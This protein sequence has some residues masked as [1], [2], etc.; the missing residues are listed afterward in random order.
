MDHLDEWA[1]WNEADPELPET[2]VGNATPLTQEE[3][4]PIE[5]GAYFV[6][7]DG[8]PSTTAG[9]TFLI[10]TEGWIGSKEGVNFN[11]MNGVS[12][13][14][15]HLKL[16]EEPFTPV[17]GLSGVTAGVPLPAGSTAADLVDGF[18]ASGFTVLEAPAPVSAFGH[19][20]Y[21]VV[22]E[23][24]EGC[25]F[26]GEGTPHIWVYPGDVI[27]VWSFDMDGSI[28]MVEALWLTE[29]TLEE[30]LAVLRA[31]IDTLVLT[32]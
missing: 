26:G 27:E 21:H 30:D 2:A 20:G 15:L 4:E 3:Y 29:P 32:P 5:P 7:A 23:V 10:E 31:V 19:D 22:V 9:A 25:Q 12:P 1:A 13:H 8:D 16:F 17:C 28:A 11:G 6:D 14:T 24:P 18:A